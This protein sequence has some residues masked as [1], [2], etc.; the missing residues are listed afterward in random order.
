[1]DSPGRLVT[2]ATHHRSA[3]E[4]FLSEFDAN[5][6]ELHGYFCPRD[7]S[8]EEVVRILHAWSVGEE[9]AAG[10]VPSSTWFWE[11]EGVLQ[12]VINVR[13][14]L[15][16]GLRE[17]GGNIGYSVAKSYRRRGVGKTMLRD[18]LPHCQALGIKRVLLTCDPNNTA[19]ARTI[20]AN[21]GE[22]VREERLESTSQRIQRRYWIDLDA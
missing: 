20:E 14:K 4:V 7:S 16:P 11:S 1:M 21:G 2:L 18:V 3:L 12:G 9:L 19:S 6:E 22:K 15:T 17:F 13:H 5:P 8:I 10:W